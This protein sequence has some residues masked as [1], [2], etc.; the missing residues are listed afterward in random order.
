M[1]NH[2]NDKPFIVFNQLLRLLFI[3]NSKKVLL[4]SLCISKCFRQKNLNFRKKPYT[5]TVVLSNLRRDRDL[6]NTLEA[7]NSKTIGQKNL[8]WVHLESPS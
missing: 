2:N 8:M 5:Y 4:S 6:I 3:M 1:A 7:H